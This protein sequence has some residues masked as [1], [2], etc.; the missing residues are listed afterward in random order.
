MIENARSGDCHNFL[1]IR[2]WYLYRLFSTI[3]QYVA[4]IMHGDLHTYFYGMLTVKKERS[5]HIGRRVFA[6]RARA[7]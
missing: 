7:I 6:Q 2:V 1:E 5:F 3:S 4:K